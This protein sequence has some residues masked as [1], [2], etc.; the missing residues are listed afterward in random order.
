[1]FID[2]FSIIGICSSKA[3][4]FICLTRSFV[5]PIEFP[6]SSKVLGDLFKPKYSGI[7]KEINIITG[8]TNVK[9]GDYVNV[10]DVLVLPFNINANGEKVYDLKPKDNTT[11]AE[12]TAILNRM[13]LR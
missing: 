12:I 10:G 7:I 9:V 13:L 4:S 5:S 3:F 11:R 1:M 8:T 2:F 6:I